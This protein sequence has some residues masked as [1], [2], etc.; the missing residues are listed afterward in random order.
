VDVLMSC[1]RDDAVACRQYSNDADRLWSYGNETCSHWQ[2]GRASSHAEQ[3][4][5]LSAAAACGLWQPSCMG[6]D[7][8]WTLTLAKCCFV[9]L[10]STQP[11]GTRIS[12]S[13]RIVNRESA[14]LKLSREYEIKKIE[15]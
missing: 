14:S 1:C 8:R 13:V 4:K 9:S 11:C 3:H 15:T 6:R 7:W 5:L 10:H 12:I 2:V